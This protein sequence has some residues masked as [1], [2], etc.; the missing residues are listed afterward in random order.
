[1]HAL[2]PPKCIRT[3]SCVIK[4][5]TYATLSLSASPQIVT[6]YTLFAH[7]QLRKSLSDPLTQNKTKKLVISSVTP[8]HLA[9]PGLLVRVGFTGHD[10]RLLTGRIGAMSDTHS[11][12]SEQEDA[13]DGG[14][15]EEALVG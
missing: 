10:T 8:G 14:E 5:C 3:C 12:E 9:T 7:Q 6:V 13:S 15:D 11:N 4:A 2:L 1:M